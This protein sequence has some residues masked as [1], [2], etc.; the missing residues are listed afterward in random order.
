MIDWHRVRTAEF[1]G[2]E[3]VKRQETSAARRLTM[4]D[5]LQNVLVSAYRRAGR[6]TCRAAR[7]RHDTHGRRVVRRR[8]RVVGGPAAR[9][10]IP[11][12][13]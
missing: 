11:R 9:T 13:P 1:V 4:K 8:R 3:I 5:A 12:L 7:D 10:T 6:R 2:A